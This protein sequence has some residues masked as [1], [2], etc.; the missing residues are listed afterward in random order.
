MTEIV[1]DA[2]YKIAAWLVNAIC[3]HPAVVGWL[4]VVFIVATLVNT[5]IKGTW[6]YAEMPK[7]ARF[8]LSFTMPLA[9]NFYHWAGKIGVQEPPSLSPRAVADAVKRDQP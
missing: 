9:L 6:T 2:G 5:G 3:E 8:V 4:C 1:K 7:W